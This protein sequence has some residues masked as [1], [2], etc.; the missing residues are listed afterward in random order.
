[1]NDSTSNQ[2]FI[3]YFKLYFGFLYY[4]FT[5]TNKIEKFSRGASNKVMESLYTTEMIYLM[6][7][8]ISMTS[9]KY[10]LKLIF[11]IDNN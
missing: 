6:S 3:N 8:K 10:N 11:V 1:M 2:R 7:L 5:N 9:I 4:Y